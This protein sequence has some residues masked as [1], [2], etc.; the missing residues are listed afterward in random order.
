MPWHTRHTQ[1][2]QACFN[3]VFFFV[4]MC[5]WRRDLLDNFVVDLQD[6]T[7]NMKCLE[8]IFLS[9][10]FELSGFSLERCYSVFSAILGTVYRLDS[11]T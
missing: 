2:R 11:K 7:S 5:S 8:N 3:E 6:R 10:D 4:D 1:G 9:I